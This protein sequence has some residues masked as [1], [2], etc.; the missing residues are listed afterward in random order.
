MTIPFFDRAWVMP[1]ALMQKMADKGNPLN[2]SRV[3]P[4]LGLSTREQ[5]RSFHFRDV[6]VPSSFKTPK[7]ADSSQTPNSL[8]FYRHDCYHFFVDASNRNLMRH[9]QI[10]TA[11]EEEAKGIRLKPMVSHLANFSEAYLDRE[12]I[13]EFRWRSTDLYRNVLFLHDPWLYQDNLFLISIGYLASMALP[14]DLPRLTKILARALQTHF[15]DV[16]FEKNRDAESMLSAMSHMDEVENIVN[17]LL[18][19]AI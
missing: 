7:R 9:Q 14:E 4:V 1:P 5:M 2:K 11:I 13:L 16:K 19:P 3:R 8:L 15:P 6:F 10:Y 18:I 17:Q 12:F